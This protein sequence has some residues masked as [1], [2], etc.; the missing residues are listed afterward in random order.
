MDKTEKELLRIE[1][2]KILNEI[3][4]F[5]IGDIPEDIEIREDKNEVWVIK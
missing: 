3:G 1:F 2:D 4:I 5:K